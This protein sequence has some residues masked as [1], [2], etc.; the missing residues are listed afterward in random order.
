MSTQSQGQIWWRPLQ[1]V[2]AVGLILLG[3]EVATGGGWQLVL[4]AFLLVV[5]GLVWLGRLVLFA[6][7]T[8]GQRLARTRKAVVFVA[9]N[10]V[11]VL[12][13]LVGAS[14]WRMGPTQLLE[15]WRKGNH[16]EVREQQTDPELG[17]APVAPNHIVGM[18]LEPVDPTKPRIL[19]IGD[20]IVYG[21]D[22]DADKTM[23][24]EMQR[25]LPGW[26]VLNGGVRG[27]SAEQEYI[28]LKRII[29]A[30]KPHLVILGE[31]SG[32]DFSTAGREFSWG[33]SKPL[34]MLQRSASHPEGEL[35]RVDHAGP[36][37]DRLSQ[38]LLYRLMWQRK[39][40]A[41]SVIE[42]LC[43][44][45]SLNFRQTRE[46][47]AAFYREIDKLSAQHGAKVLHVVMEEQREY[48]TDG[49]SDDEYLLIRLFGH[50]IARIVAEGGH[51]WM[52]SYAV[53]GQPKDIRDKAF[54]EDHAHL[55]A[56]GHAVLAEAIVKRLAQPDFAIGPHPQLPVDPTASHH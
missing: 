29:G 9:V 45:R 1:F 6:R 37:I 40:F 17:W 28:Y 35:V 12:L 48:H 16:G 3:L 20:S 10:T 51:T 15:P 39:D 50:E 8:A 18:R 46:T 13:V 4:V 53:L 24:Q 43:E 26:Q 44:P 21:Q 32:N 27:Y 7:T 2:L 52:G 55:T 11:T 42:Y 23:S 54:L 25:R 49:Y 38:S 41:A 14:L 30:V 56:L 47:I 22:V 5:L 36:C 34:Y 31:Y 33:H 19:F